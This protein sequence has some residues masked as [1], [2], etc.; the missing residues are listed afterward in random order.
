MIAK[1]HAD[2]AAEG[3]E[4]SKEDLQAELD[5]CYEDAA[6]KGA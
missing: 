2:L 1:V 6:A 5:L 3:I 4:I